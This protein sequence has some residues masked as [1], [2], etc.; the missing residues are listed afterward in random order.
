MHIFFIDFKSR[1]NKSPKLIDQNG[2]CYDQPGNK[3]NEPF[4]YKHSLNRQNLEVYGICGVSC[5]V[6]KNFQDPINISK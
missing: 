3:G 6:K 2:E 4:N 5:W 1:C